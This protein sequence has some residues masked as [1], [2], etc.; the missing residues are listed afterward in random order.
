MQAPLPPAPEEEVGQFSFE[1]CAANLWA[2][3]FGMILGF[4]GGTGG[5]F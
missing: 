4:G 5:V 1:F 2:G 3:F